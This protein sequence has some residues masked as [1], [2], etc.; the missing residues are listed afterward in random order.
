MTTTEHARLSDA[1]R[2]LAAYDEARAMGLSDQSARIHAA[3]RGLPTVAAWDAMPAVGRALADRAAGG[4]SM[5][6]NRGEVL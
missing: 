1:S 6:L 3:R 5:T 4:S 2:V